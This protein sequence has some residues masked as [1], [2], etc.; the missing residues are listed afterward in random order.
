MGEGWETRRRRDDGHDHAVIRLG[1][2]G[3]V[4]QAVVDTREFRYNASA[5]V[6]LW[7]HGAR[8]RPA[9]DD[10]GWAPLLPRTA[11]QPDTRHVFEIVSAETIEWVRVDAFPDGGLARLRLHG[12]VDPAARR[13]AGHRWFNALPGEQALACLEAGGVPPD[14]AAAVVSARPL[15]DPWRRSLTPELKAAAGAILARILE[16]A[17]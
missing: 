9:F 11:L 3:T 2:A 6:E 14:A 5:A 12:A 8:S 7:G 15:S 17:G 10:P 1:L 4:R 13:R 16:G